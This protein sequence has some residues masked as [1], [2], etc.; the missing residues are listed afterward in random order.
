MS[1]NH[2]YYTLT[3]IFY[4]V[5]CKRMLLKGP[6]HEIFDPPYFHQTFFVEISAVSLILSFRTDISENRTVIKKP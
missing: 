5:S 4:I 6:C 2:Q 3:A 1:V